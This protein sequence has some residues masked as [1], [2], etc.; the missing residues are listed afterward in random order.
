MPITLLLSSRTQ[1]SSLDDGGEDGRRRMVLSLYGVVLVIV[2]RMT[3]E[4]P[5]NHTNMT[6]LSSSQLIR[7]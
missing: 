2:K 4:S 6:A 7:S 1:N 3:Q 5:K